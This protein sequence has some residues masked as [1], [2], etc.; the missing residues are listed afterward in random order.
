MDTKDKK[1]QRVAI[2]ARVSSQEQAV[3]GVSIDAQIAALKANAKI[4]G[5]EIYDEYFCQVSTERTPRILC[6][7]SASNAEVLF[8]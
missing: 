3:E 4:K 7:F 6:H 2:Y 1:Q 5:W 8:V